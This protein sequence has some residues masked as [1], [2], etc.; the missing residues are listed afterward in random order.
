GDMLAALS[1]EK[2]T[3]EAAD[4][5]QHQKFTEKYGQEGS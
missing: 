4:L 3:I 1:T 5:R 2:A